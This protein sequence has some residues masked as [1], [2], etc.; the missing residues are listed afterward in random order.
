MAITQDQW[1]KYASS[2]LY[3]ETHSVR[4]VSAEGTAKVAVYLIK[5]FSTAI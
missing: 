5:L 3:I 4:G 1:G 2:V